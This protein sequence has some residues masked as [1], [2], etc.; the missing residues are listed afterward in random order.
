M[1]PFLF[2]HPRPDRGSRV[3]VFAFVAVTSLLGGGEGHAGCR[4]VVSKKRKAAIWLPFFLDLAV[5]MRSA[6]RAYG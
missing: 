4:I 1:T 3:F 2:C 6:T 5:R